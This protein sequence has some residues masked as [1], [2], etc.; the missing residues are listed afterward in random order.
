MI[1]VA[2]IKQRTSTPIA[3]KAEVRHLGT[4]SL[5]QDDV[6]DASGNFLGEIEEIILDAHTGGVRHVVLALGGFLGM[7]RKRIA[8]PWHAIVPDAN[9]RRC[10]LDVTLAQLVAVA[11]PRDDPWLQ[12]AEQATAHPDAYACGGNSSLASPGPCVA[13]ALR[14][15]SS[16]NKLWQTAQVCGNPFRITPVVRK[17]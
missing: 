2:Q 3:S 9:Y 15:V 4:S 13:W 17:T 11:V 5:M 16:A 6:Y 12:R 7:G 14:N 1:N 8:V 10:V